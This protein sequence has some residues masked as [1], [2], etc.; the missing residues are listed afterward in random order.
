MKSLRHRLTVTLG[1]VVAVLAVS[2]AAQTDVTGTWD[3][4]T[5]SEQGSTSAVL[6]LSQDGDKLTGEFAAPEVGTVAFEGTITGD[7]LEWTLE[8]DAGGQAIEITFEGTV[9]GDEMTG[10]L[11]V[12]GYFGGDWTAKRME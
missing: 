11:D 12:A 1:I 10:T 3:V 8:F 5:E 9:D 6:T 2:V 7:K 4:T